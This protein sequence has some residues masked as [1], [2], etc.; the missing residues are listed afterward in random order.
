MPRLTTAKQRTVDCATPCDT[1][2]AVEKSGIGGQGVPHSP[3]PHSAR[4]PCVVDWPDPHDYES[5]RLTRFPKQSKT[6]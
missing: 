3:G 4:L 2:A 5:E 1:Q 6:M